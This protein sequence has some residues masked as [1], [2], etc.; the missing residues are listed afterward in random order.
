MNRPQRRSKQR[1]RPPAKRPTTPDLWRVP[2]PLPE[3]EPI[4]VSDDPGALLRSLGDP[5]MNNGHVAGHY[6]NAVIERAAAVAGALALSADL[7]AEAE[8]D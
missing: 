8:R 4:A 2:A 7:Y 1:R 6:F 3:T 5:P